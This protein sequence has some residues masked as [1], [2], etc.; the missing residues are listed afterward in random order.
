VIKAVI[1]DMDGL[2]IDSEPF[3]RE[4]ESA[5][6][7]EL[8]LNLTES[9]F[10]SVMG[11]RIDEVVKHWYHQ[12]PWPLK[13]LKEVEQ[14]VLSGVESLICEKGNLMEGVI[15][16]LEYLQTKNLKLAIASSSPLKIIDLVVTKFEIKKYFKIIHSAQFEEYGKP[17]PCIYLNTAK[18]L[19]VSPNECLVFE[20][21]FNGLISAK[22][23]RMKT[24]VIPAFNTWHQT[25]FDIA[26]FKLH[27]LLEFNDGYFNYL[28]QT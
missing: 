25:K 26:D 5:V 21:S 4:S 6:F 19:S 28:N 24:T 1:F 15:E 2:L 10:E 23:A 3:W 7:S 20:D 22:A 18:Q 9:D 16:I 12:K 17:H 14:L 27:S 8:G 11:L 13:S